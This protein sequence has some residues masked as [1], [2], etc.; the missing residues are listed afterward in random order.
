MPQLTLTV[1]KLEDVPETARSYYKKAEGDNAT[2]FILDV[3]SVENHPEVTGLKNTLK[4][5]KP[6][7][8]LVERIK[9]RFPD[10][11]D[12]DALDAAI[13]TA[14]EA[15]KKAGTGKGKVDEDDIAR[16]VEKDLGEKMKEIEPKLQAGEIA[17]KELRSERIENQARRALAKAG[18]MGEREETAVEL[19]VKSLTL[20]EKNI[21]KVVVLDKDGDPRT[22]S[23][24]DFAAKDFKK[25]H[26][27]LFAGTGASGSGAEG[28]RRSTTGDMSKMSSAEKIKAG[29]AE[30]NL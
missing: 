2:G 15:A 18:V 29:L 24:E 4:T 10:A 22:I 28:S 3:D 19:L 25:L 26:P 9:K 17:Q 30:R 5:L 8:K 23:L 6:A 27:Y 16:R 21:K 20:D 12:D 11:A 14:V 13:Q 7:G 1:E